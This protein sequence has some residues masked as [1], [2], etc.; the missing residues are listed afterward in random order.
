[1]SSAMRPPSGSAGEEL[2]EFVGS[3]RFENIAPHV[4][5]IA[6]LH[7]L[8]TVGCAFA[9][10]TCDTTRR[11]LRFLTIEHAAGP[12]PVL[13]TSLSFGP[14]AAAFGNAAAMNALD[15]DDGYEVD[16]RGMGH[17]GASLLAA[18]LSAVWINECS[19]RDFLAAITAGYE[20][21]NRLIRSM[22]PSIARFKQVYGVC[23]HQ[24]VGSAAIYGRL[25]GL[26]ASQLVNAFGFAATL[27]NVPSLR[28][29]N[30]AERPL[31]SL[32]DFNAPA[33]EA[34]VRAVQLAEAGLIGSKSV[35]DDDDGYWRM[36]GSDRFDRT[37]LTGGLGASW[38]LENNS[39]K[40][41]PACRWL[42]AALEAL[43]GLIAERAPEAVQITELR[44]KT[45]SVLA[46]G[47]LDAEPR[48]MVDAQFSLPY[49]AAAV[50]LKVP[51]AQW[52]TDETLGR[53]DVIE[54]SAR[55][56]A[57]ADPG[58]DA[59]FNERR[60]HGAEAVLRIGDVELQSP[61]LDG[62]KG[63]AERPL[64]ERDILAKFNDN[65]G[66]ALGTRAASRLEHAIMTIE[67]SERLD[68]LRAALARP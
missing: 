18:A 28:K 42:H 21:N 14:A 19:G 53:R 36:A 50:A 35:F 12:C 33:A 7:L 29:Y 41:Y 25:A 63:G 52:Y 5:Q 13:G 31:I 55:V 11:F 8:D 46:T 2:A 61:R 10:A 20:V 66:P 24:T 3:L 57:D 44:F 17:P 30:F 54:L 26:N 48:T 47:F 65:V 16:G 45:T 4:V 64:P 51:P 56:R 43:E 22:Q 67:T 40:P 27:A 15:F 1:M 59:A 38:S 39:I 49:C 58:F 32:K 34:G 23:Q 9:G 68:E 62:P 37:I 60:V 6:K